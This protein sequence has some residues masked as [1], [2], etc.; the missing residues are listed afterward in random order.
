MNEKLIKKI[1]EIYNK[2]QNG[3]TLVKERNITGTIPYDYCVL[4]EDGQQISEELIGLSL[5]GFFISRK[6]G[7]FKALIKHKGLNVT[8]EV[9]SNYAWHDGNYVSQI[10]LEDEMLLDFCHAFDKDAWIEE[11]L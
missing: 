11:N 7:F 1:C 4:Y 8:D 10:H 9:S 6:F 2:W 5:H 3:Y